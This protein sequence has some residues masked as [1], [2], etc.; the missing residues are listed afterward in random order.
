MVVVGG[1]SINYH[2]PIKYID[3]SQANPAINL[4]DDPRTNIISFDYD[5][6]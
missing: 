4:F 1:K 5:I 2:L 3:A 6:H